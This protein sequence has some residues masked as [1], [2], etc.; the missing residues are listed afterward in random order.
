M[1]AAARLSRGA[2]ASEGRRMFLAQH[3]DGVAAGMRWAFACRMPEIDLQGSPY[4]QGLP[5]HLNQIELDVYRLLAIFASSETLSARRADD[6]DQASVYGFSI[7]E[8]EYAEIGRI[9]IATAAALRNEWDAAPHRFDER[10]GAAV[11]VGQL[12]ENV[13]LPAMTSELTLR[14]SFNKIIHSNTLNLERSRGHH[15]FSGHLEPRLHFYGWR[16]DRRWKA[17]LD[18][19]AWCE[20]VHAIC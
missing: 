19:F 5:R 9:L 17:T 13:D 8:Y 14:E 12:V 2:G 4:V 7:R 20:A 3:E 16:G 10:E 15:L 1:P 6:D 18:V 11:S